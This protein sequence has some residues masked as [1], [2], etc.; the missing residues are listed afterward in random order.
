MPD[1]YTSI[2]I[3][4]K[5]PVPN[6]LVIT[7]VVFIFL[8]IVGQFIGQITVNPDRQKWAGIVGVVFLLLGISLYIV[9]NV[10]TEDATG[11][12]PNSID[13][14]QIQTIRIYEG[15]TENIFDNDLAI[16]LDEFTCMAT[17]ANTI[18]AIIGSPGMQNLKIDNLK[19]GDTNYYQGKNPY[20]IRFIRKSYFCNWVEFQ[21]AKLEYFPTPT[22]MLGEGQNVVPITVSKNKSEVIFDGDLVITI[23]S[24]LGSSFSGTLGSPNFPNQE[25]SGARVGDVIIYE[26]KDTY[27]IR[28]MEQSLSDV[29]LRITK[30]QLDDVTPTPTPTQ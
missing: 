4:Q 5:T 19:L 16:T 10:K 17:Y 30:L 22:I 20:E 1:I 15:E 23:T 25:I 7:G 27:S 8:A 29:T 13:T 9:P 24:I 6:I 28:V 14:S 21:I 12:S 3:L 2:Q 26:G 18:D 11:A